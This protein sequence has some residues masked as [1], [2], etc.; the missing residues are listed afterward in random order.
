MGHGLGWGQRWG[1]AQG[2]RQVAWNATLLPSF[3]C[4]GRTHGQHTVPSQAQGVKLP[5]S[6]SGGDSANDQGLWQPSKQKAQEGR[7]PCR[8]PRPREPAVREDPSTE[9]REDHQ[10]EVQTDGTR[11]ESQ[12]KMREGDG[13]GSRWGSREI[14]MQELGG[15]VG[16]RP[17]AA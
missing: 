16:T 6:H 5:A 2:P 1:L 3:H 17:P 7:T 4:P 13:G 12:E 11:V 15:T 14:Q 10:E 8:P 9:R